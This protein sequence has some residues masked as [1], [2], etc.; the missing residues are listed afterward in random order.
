MDNLFWPKFKSNSVETLVLSTKGSGAIKYPNKKLALIH[1]LPPALDHRSRWNILNCKNSRRK[2]RTD[3]FCILGL[4]TKGFL[5]IT[6]KQKST[7]GETDK[8][9]FIWKNYTSKDP[10]IRIKR[11]A[12]DWEI[13]LN[14]I[15]YIY[16]VHIEHFQNAIEK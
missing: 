11:Q 4:N 1:T 6:P 16:P 12:I 15:N 9:N 8:S 13:F 2:Y 14:H 10:V 7:E 3:V 5:N